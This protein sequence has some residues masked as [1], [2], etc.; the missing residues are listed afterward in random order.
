MPPFRKTSNLYNLFRGLVTF[1]MR[2]IPSCSSILHC[3]STLL[4]NDTTFVWSP[5]C[6]KAFNKVKSLLASPPV[7][8]HFETSKSVVVEC[9]A[10]LYG[11]GACLLQQGPSGALQP[12]WDVSR[13]LTAPER[14][15][16]HI[17]KEALAIVFAVKRLHQLSVWSQLHTLNRSQAAHEDI[18][19]E[20]ASPNGHRSHIAAPARPL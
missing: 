12:V 10:S 4:K 1:Y 20:R 19:S 11:V 5:E 3:L 2:F 18:R 16:S 6:Q 13:S 14:N 8:I 9:D 15:Y 17:E 7:L